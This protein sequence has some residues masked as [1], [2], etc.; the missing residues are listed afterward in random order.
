[1]KKP[2]DRLP[3]A[4]V[5]LPGLRG[6][7]SVFVPLPLSLD[8]CLCSSHDIQVP[9]MGKEG[10]GAVCLLPSFYRFLG[11]LFRLLGKYHLILNKSHWPDLSHMTIPTGQWI[12]EKCLVKNEGLVSEADYMPHYFDI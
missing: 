12:R 11:R 4:G 8:G 6:T 1:M 7:G 9:V 3:K 2:T 10:R 5:L